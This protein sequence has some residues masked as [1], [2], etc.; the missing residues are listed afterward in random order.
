MSIATPFNACFL[1]WIVLNWHLELL[2]YEMQSIGV[3]WVA[4]RDGSIHL[5]SGIYL[6]FIPS[7]I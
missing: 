6:L 7:L 3:E 5:T 1:S 2:D 4:Y